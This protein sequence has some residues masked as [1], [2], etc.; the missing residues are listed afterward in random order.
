MGAPSTSLVVKLASIAVHIEEARSSDG[1]HW[2]WATIDSL[3]TDPEVRGFLDDPDNA[4]LLPVKRRRL[5]S[6]RRDQ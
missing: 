5:P 2:D 3:L 6:Q 4:V 1:H